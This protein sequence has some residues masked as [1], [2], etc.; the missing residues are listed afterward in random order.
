MDNTEDGQRELVE[1][2]LV[3]LSMADTVWDLAGP[4]DR[5]NMTSAPEASVDDDML[6]AA[7]SLLLLSTHPIINVG[8]Q[9]ASEDTSGRDL[10]ASAA[11]VGA[12]KS[13]DAALDVASIAP[14]AST[15]STVTSIP[16]NNPQWAGLTTDQQAVQQ[17]RLNMTA[18]QRYKQNLQPYDHV[19]AQGSVI[20][21]LWQT[22]TERRT[23]RQSQ[24]RRGA[25]LLRAATTRGRSFSSK[26]STNQK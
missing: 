17:R 4:S 11:P 6:E 9:V 5:V 3:L 18:W 1:A 8:D 21:R 10:S 14:D 26:H 23:L 24:R 15:T 13:L 25:N 7:A 19:N 16:I 22:T 2:G 12:P 20:G